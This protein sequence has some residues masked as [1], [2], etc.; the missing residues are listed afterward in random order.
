M[1]RAWCLCFAVAALAIACSSSSGGGSSSGACEGAAIP[2]SCEC[3]SGITP[4]KPVSECSAATVGKPVFCCQGQG[5]CF[6]TQ[7]GCQQVS[8]NDCTCDALG[9][10]LSQCTGTP[11]C[12]TTGQ[13]AGQCSCGM[14]C[15]ATD[16]MVA[17]CTED[18][19]QC[20]PGET[21]VDKCEPQ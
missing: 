21:R 19:L 2:T 8:A 5:D 10:S 20:P 15:G 18:V 14:S 9:G 3:G 16:M 4:V 6:C 17:S 1:R 7:Y 11:C 13:N 12:A